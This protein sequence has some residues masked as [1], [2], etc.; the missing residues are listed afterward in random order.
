MVFIKLIVI[1]LISF[2]S[3]SLD[4][5]AADFSGKTIKWTVTAEEGSNISQWASFYAPLLSKALPGN[6]EVVIKHMPTD[7]SIVGVNFFNEQ[8]KPNGLHILGTSGSAQF[9]YLLENSRIKYDYKDLNVILG[10][11]IGGVVYVSQNLGVS[12]AKD[13]KKLQRVRLKYGSAG[14]T[15]LDLIPLLAFDMMGLSV[16]VLPG[17]QSR[18]ASLSALRKGK[19]NIDYQTTPLFTNEVLKDVKEGKVVPLFTW[20]IIGDE[21]RF[22]RDP[23]FPDLPHFVEAYEMMHGK[24]PAGSAF[25]VFKAFF[26]AGFSMQKVIFLPA[27]TSQDI[28]DTYIESIDEIITTPN[29][30]QNNSKLLGGYQQLT[31]YEV[32]ILKQTVIDVIS[33]HWLKKW[34]KSKYNINL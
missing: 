33:K 2:V 10:A 11:P 7:N 27:G 18:K 6:P 20:G 29:F 23:S 5:L 34:L 32:E 24:T 9:S 15:S 19:V 4:T 16:R 17:I 14:A 25:N 12:S 8:A 28:I 30:S 26:T 1:V 31:G 22:Q 13:L 21:G 3:L